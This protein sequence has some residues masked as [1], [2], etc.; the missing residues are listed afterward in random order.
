MTSD[1]RWQRVGGSAAEVYE[2]QLVP[3]MFAPW[4]PVL[5]DV[6]DVQSGERVI[7]I[8]SGTGVVARL[9]AQRVGPGGRVVALDLNPAMLA[10]GQAAAE[11]E[12]IAIEWLEADSQAVPLPDSVFD[13]VLCQHGLQQFPDRPAALGEMHRLLVVGGRLAAC[14]WSPI[15]HS[16]G[17]AALAEALERHVS[18]EAGKNRRNPFALSDA[19]ELHRLLAD[20]GFRDIEV[21]TRTLPTGFPSPDALVAAQLAATPLATLGA[22]TDDTRAAITAEVRSALSAY[23]DDGHYAIPMQAH[24]AFA[25]RL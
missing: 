16:P 5:L 11:A 9:A 12:G 24:I 15:E 10:V 21:T 14:V 23:L 7:D 19:D 18:P 17:M 22:I 20:A 25:R 4:A 1:T 8:A 2:H 13:V 6:A 3:G